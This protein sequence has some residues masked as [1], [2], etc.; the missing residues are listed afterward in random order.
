MQAVSPFAGAPPSPVILQRNDDHQQESK[1]ARSSRK[2]IERRYRD[3]IHEGI[4]NLGAAVPAI[5]ILK[6]G[7]QIQSDGGIGTTRGYVDGVRVPERR[8]KAAI[9]DK[10]R[11]YIM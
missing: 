4:E 8:S 1:W 3:S 5:R 10:A 6:E 2:K 7:F 11:E 9:L